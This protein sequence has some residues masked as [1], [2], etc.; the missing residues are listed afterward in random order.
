M[1]DCIFTALPEW[2]Q[3]IILGEIVA[4][5][6]LLIAYVFIQIIIKLKK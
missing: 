3:T 2:M 6:V 5:N 4:F 1:K